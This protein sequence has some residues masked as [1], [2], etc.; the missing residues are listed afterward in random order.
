MSIQNLNGVWTITDQS[1]DKELGTLIVDNQGVNWNNNN[2]SDFE[3]DDDKRCLSWG[4]KTESF[5][6]VREPNVL[7]G[8]AFIDGQAFNNV[9]GKREI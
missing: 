1:S 7:T 3:Y 5:R 2:I 9:V 6:F 4:N 8:N